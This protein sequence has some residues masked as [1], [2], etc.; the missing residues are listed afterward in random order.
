[1]GRQNMMQ[2][3]RFL[4][5]GQKP[6]QEP[7]HYRACG[8]D[9][10]YLISGFARESTPYGEVV[11]IADVEGLHWEIGHLII[12][13]DKPLSPREFRFLRKNM[14]LTQEQLAKRLKID[15]QTIARYEKE[16]T[17]IPGATDMVVRIMFALYIVPSDKR[18]E[19]ADEIRAIIEDQLSKQRRKKVGVATRWQEQAAHH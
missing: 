7:H 13:D 16:Q 12:C 11:K 10:I 19:V 3:R 4:M 17:A 9:D 1:M 8:L 2:K 5:R 15:A 18:A 6:A 14:N